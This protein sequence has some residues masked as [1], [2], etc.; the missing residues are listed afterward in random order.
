MA[1]KPIHPTLSAQIGWG[2]L[3]ERDYNYFGTTDAVFVFNPALELEM[4]FTR[5]FRLGVAAHYRIVTGVNPEMHNSRYTNSDM[6][7]PGGMLIF[8]FGWF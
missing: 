2:S 5:F 8:R 3:A 7:G 6:S 4:N 1:T